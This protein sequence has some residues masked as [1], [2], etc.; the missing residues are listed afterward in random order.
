MTPEGKVKRDV[1]EYL[2]TL[3][4]CWYFMPVPFGYGIRGVPD[5]VVCHKGRFVGIE[6]KSSKGPRKAWQ[7]AVGALIVQAGGAYFVIRSL[8]ELKK[9]LP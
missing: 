9:C 6:T 5:F 7:E 2:K 4:K 8:E 1:K 3:D